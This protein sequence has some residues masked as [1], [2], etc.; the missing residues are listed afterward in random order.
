[1]HTRNQGDIGEKCAEKYLIR[2]G[3]KIIWRNYSTFVGEVDIVA[4]NDDR[5]LVFV[6]VR[7]K[8]VDRQET[9]KED[10]FIPPEDSISFPKIKKIE[11]TAQHFLKYMEKY[12][13]S[14]VKN[15]REPDFPDWR[16]DLVSVI[17]VKSENKALIRHYEYIY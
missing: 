12:W 1:M 13:S 6:E 5:E 8:W 2:K 7:S 17:F 14:L 4:T 9:I 16:I 11:K 15:I 10:Y 3:F